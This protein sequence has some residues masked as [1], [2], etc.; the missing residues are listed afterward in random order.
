M[1]GVLG[2]LMQRGPAGFEPLRVNTDVA[3]H[4]VELMFDSPEAVIA[5]A[6]SSSGFSAPANRRNEHLRQV[7]VESSGT[8]LN[9]R[10]ELR[11]VFTASNVQSM[12]DVLVAR[13]GGGR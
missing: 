9:W 5:W 3:Y 8:V 11:Y 12:P 1:F 10:V 4:L 2:W 7:V 13:T 6:K